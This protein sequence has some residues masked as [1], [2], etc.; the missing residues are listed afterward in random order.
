[1]LATFSAES[2]KFC[3]ILNHFVQ[4]CFRIAICLARTHSG[5]TFST[6]HGPLLAL[7][8]PI[9]ALRNLSLLGRFALAC[10][11][12]RRICQI[13]F[14]FE[15]FCSRMLQNRNL[16]GTDPFRRHLFHST[17]PFFGPVLTHL[18]P[19]ESVSARQA[20]KKLCCHIFRCGR[21]Q[22]LCRVNNFPIPIFPFTKV[23]KNQNST[24]QESKV[25]RGSLGNPLLIYVQQG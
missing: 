5:G 11:I 10:H 18:R 22:R 13:L 19:Q 17:W 12:F 16:P 8:C 1:M 4:D 15:S 6:Q 7:S 23:F 3:F 2:V 24:L 21:S 14:Y 9:C 25:I 20:P